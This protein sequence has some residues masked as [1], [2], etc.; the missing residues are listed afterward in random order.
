MGEYELMGW[1]A[2]DVEVIHRSRAAQVFLT[3]ISSVGV[4]LTIRFSILECQLSLINT[5]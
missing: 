3:R 1:L 5:R 2:G 4:Y